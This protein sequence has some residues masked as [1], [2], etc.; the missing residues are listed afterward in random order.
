MTQIPYGSVYFRKSNPPKADWERDYIVASEDGMNAFRHWFLWGAI[1]TSKGEYDWSDYDIQLE[2][3]AQQGMRTVIAEMITSVPEWLAAEE[4]D[5][6]YT[7]SDGS[8]LKTRMGVSTAT[9]G[10]GNGSSG[11]ICLDHPKA[12]QYAASFLTE[13]VLR[14][15]DHPSL[16]GYDVW[17]ECNYSPSVCY[18]HYTKEKFREWL[19]KK[20]GDLMTLNQAWRRYSYTS[21]E[22]VEPPVALAP[23]PEHEDW[24]QFRKENFYEQMRWRIELIRSLDPKGLIIAHGIAGSISHMA[25]MG[26]DDWAAAA[27]VDVYGFTWVASRKGNEPWKLWHAVDLTRSAANG[28]EFWHAETQGGPLWLQPQVIGRKKEDGRVASPED[29]RVWQLTSFAGGARGI[30]FPRWRPL[31][32]GPLFGA[33]GPYAMNG[34]RTERS[35]MASTIAK[36][37]N[38]K[39]QRP[40]WEAKPL[41]GD[42]GLLILPEAQIFD[43]LLHSDG[44]QPLYSQAMW[45]AYQGFFDNHIQADWIRMDQVDQYKVIYLAYPLRMDQANVERLIAWIEQ[46]GTLIAEGCPAYFGNLG[47]AGTVQ[48]NYGLDEVFGAQECDVEFTPDLFDELTFGWNGNRIYGGGYRQAYSPLHGKVTGRY[49]DG[50]PAVIENAHKKGRTFLVGS[51]PSEAYFRNKAHG[52]RMFFAELAAWAGV[53]PAV[54]IPDD[55][56]GLH[57][58]VHRSPNGDLMLWLINY[59]LN[60]LETT[61]QLAA[62]FGDYRLDTVFWGDENGIRKRGNQLSVKLP[63][64]DA[65]IVHCIKQEQ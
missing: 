22:Q 59:S 36:W 7:L 32:D 17:N 28:K 20:Y 15:K 3:A 58:R 37:A 35:E 30:F 10:F 11:V 21:W 61:I 54:R 6:A 34:A 2:L 63:S 18:C 57:G 46:G 38:A 4:P 47:R 5:L 29:I 25:L 16:I 39:E 45:G 27:E 52:N 41:K 1:E 23:Y 12:K 13:L 33:F 8:K 44:H 31:L 43:H 49:P 48:P 14:Y 55:V 26:A 50:K 60:E 42:I 40:L 62:A 56:E 19:L 9:G 24:L 53:E 64:K 51:L 65:L